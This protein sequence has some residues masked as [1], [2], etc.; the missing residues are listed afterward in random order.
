MEK[1]TI[2]GN[3]YLRRKTNGYHN[4]FYRG[5]GDEENPQ[6]LL[7]LKNTFAYMDSK[8]INTLI[9]ARQIVEKILIEDIPKIMDIEHWSDCIC[10]C[11][12]RAKAN[13]RPVQLY[14]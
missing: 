7:D 12:P 2:W 13:M 8:T 5:Y 1:F 3:E 11:I 10:V 4:L 9:K 6:F 14:F